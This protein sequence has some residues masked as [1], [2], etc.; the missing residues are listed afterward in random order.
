MKPFLICYINGAIRHR[1]M[2]L[3]PKVTL[4][5]LCKVHSRVS[6]IFLQTYVQATGTISHSLIL[7]QFCFAY[8]TVKPLE[9]YTLLASHTFHPKHA[10]RWVSYFSLGCY[11][12]FF[13]G[14][15]RIKS[16][17]KEFSIIVIL[18]GNLERQNS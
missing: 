17:A 4:A 2:G 13:G 1:G 12:L 3:L 7:N 18:K 6:L 5:N 14:P 9:S 11:Y 10:A 8:S 15:L 16:P